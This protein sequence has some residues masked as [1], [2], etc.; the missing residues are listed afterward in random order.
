MAGKKGGI[1]AELSMHALKNPHDC[2]A[3]QVFFPLN[4][5]LFKAK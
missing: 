5:D 1:T 2:K 3:Q 4:W